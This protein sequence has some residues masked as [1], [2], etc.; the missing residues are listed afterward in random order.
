MRIMAMEMRCWRLHLLMSCKDHITNAVMY[1]KI[2]RSLQRDLNNYE[3]G[4]DYDGLDKLKDRVA[5]VKKKI[6]TGT[7]PGKRKCEGKRKMGGYDQ[8]GLT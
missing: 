4:K 6:L 1:N 8:S 3:N 7:V 5:F 2:H